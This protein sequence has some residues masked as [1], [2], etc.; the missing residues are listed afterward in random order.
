MDDRSKSVTEKLRGKHVR[1]LELLEQVVNERNALLQRVEDLERTGAKPELDV[2]ETPQLNGPSLESNAIKE[3]EDKVAASERALREVESKLK[4]KLTDTYRNIA[5]K[6]AQ[7]VTL[8]EENEKLLA[9]TLDTSLV[10]ALKEE[11]QTLSSSLEIEKDNSKRLQ[12]EA[13]LV[14][15]QHKEELAAL[16]AQ[17]RK[18]ISDRNALQTQVEALTRTKEGLEHELN[19]IRQEV[20]VENKESSELRRQLERLSKEMLSKMDIS[21]EQVDTTKELG[22]VQAENRALNSEVER[23]VKMEKSLKQQIVQLQKQSS[24]SVGSKSQ[25]AA[26]ISLKKENQLLK[27]QLDDMRAINRKFVGKPTKSNVSLPSHGGSRGL[28]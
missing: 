12:E 9:M 8:K 13:G 28:R 11:I 26:H 25:F 4:G 21:S 2:N 22:R 16:T 20:S 6:E 24:S 1:T 14:H 27:M 7:I 15:A 5:E 3:L 10:N 19:A 17:G 23:L 18:D